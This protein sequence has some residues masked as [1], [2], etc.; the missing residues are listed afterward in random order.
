MGEGVSDSVY[1]VN[2][3]IRILFFKLSEEEKID[4]LRHCLP[5]AKRVPVTPSFPASD[6]AP[7]VL[8]IEVPRGQIVAGGLLH[9]DDDLDAA[10]AAQTLLKLFPNSVKIRPRS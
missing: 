5:R 6:F 7:V 10:H 9:Q 1:S 3:H 4:F 2:E 8:E